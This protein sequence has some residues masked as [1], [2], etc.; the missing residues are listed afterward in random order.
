MAC[1]FWKPSQSAHR[2]EKDFHTMA[3]L[4]D[5]KTNRRRL[6]ASKPSSVIARSRAD[7]AKTLVMKYIKQ[8]LADGFARWDMLDNGNIRLRFITG[9]KFLLTEKEILR[10]E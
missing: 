8:L 6:G 4:H 9:E 5:A 7:S 2:D 10:L 3:S 1:S